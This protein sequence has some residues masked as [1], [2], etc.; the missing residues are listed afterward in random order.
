MAPGRTQPFDSAGHRRRKVTECH[1]KPEA[2]HSGRSHVSRANVHPRYRRSVMLA[3]GM[4]W[5]AV[6]EQRLGQQIAEN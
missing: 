3:H 5:D 4:T 1:D 6:I 2:T